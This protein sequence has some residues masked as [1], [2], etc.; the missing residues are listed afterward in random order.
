[1]SRKLTELLDRVRREYVQTMLDNGEVEPYITAHRICN[2]RLWL[3]GPRLAELIAEDPKLLT[4]RAG[5]LVDDDR[6]RPNPCVGAIV[7]SNMVAAALE[8]LLAIAVSRDWLGVDADGRVLV[9]AHELDAVGSVNGLDYTESAEFVPQRG[10]SRLSELFNQAERDFLQRLE[11]GPHDAYQL[12]LMIASDHSIF[13]PDELAPLL[14]ENPLLLG[15]RADGLVDEELFDG[16]PPAG[17]IISAHLTEM[18]VQQLLERALEVGAIA[19]DAEGQP[20]VPAS[21]DDNPTLH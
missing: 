5:D 19:H 4:A 2:Q 20:I 10:R 15:L 18:L 8:G 12:A 13:T 16:D 7:T 17:V 1:M 11:E 14:E 21:E 3:P 6:E 9:D